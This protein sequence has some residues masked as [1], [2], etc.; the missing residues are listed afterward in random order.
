VPLLLAISGNGPQ[1]RSVTTREFL[2]R[3]AIAHQFGGP[4]TPQ[5]QAWIE[6]PS[7]HV[8]GEWPHPEKIRDPGEP[9]LELDRVQ[10][11]YNT[12]RLHASTGYLTPD[13]EHQG[14]GEAARQPRRDGLDAARQ[15]RI[16]YRQSTTHKE[17]Q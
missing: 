8:N 12:V 3:A 9:G 1:M 13:D 14:R 5:D 6:T 2:A 11:Q 17:N 15:A 16:A 4:H 10:N 7:G